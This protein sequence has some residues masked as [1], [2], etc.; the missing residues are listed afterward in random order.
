MHDLGNDND[1]MINYLQTD[2]KLERSL[3]R[4]RFPQ[5][6][7][8]NQ[9]ERWLSTARLFDP[10]G[11]WY[12]V[13]RLSDWRHWEY[14]RLDAYWIPWDMRSGALRCCCTTTKT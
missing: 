14:L 7:L 13:V 10:L 12:Q 6:L 8:R 3:L 11:D 9:A 4:Q 2:T 5:T 1:Q